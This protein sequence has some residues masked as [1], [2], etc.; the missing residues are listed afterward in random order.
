M[1]Y[2]FILVIN[3]LF[4]IFQAHGQLWKELPSSTI[5]EADQYTTIPDKYVIFQLDNDAIKSLLWSCPHEDGRNGSKVQ[6]IAF[7]LANG[8]LDDFKVWEYSMMEEKLAEKYPDIKTFHGQSVSN[9]Y[10]KIRIDYT[11]RGLRA[12]ISEQYQ[13]TYIEHLNRTD[14]SL[15]MVF[16]RRDFPRKNKWTCE[17]D[18]HLHGSHSHKENNDRNL[19]AGDCQFR[20]YRLAQATTGEYSNYHGAFNQGQSSLVM[21]AVTTTINRVNEVYEQD[22]TVRLILISNTD[23]LFF[24]DPATDPYTNNNGS[25]MLGQNITTCDARIGNAN[26]DIGHV[27][28]TGG[29]GV[30]Y[31]NA[32][33]NNSLKAGG[34]TGQNQPEGDPFDIDYVAHELGHQF[35]AN[36]TQNN[37]CNRNNATAM[38]PGSAS[39]IMGYA[40]ICSPNVQSNSDA[41]FHAISIQEMSNRITSTNCHTSISFPNNPP[42]LAPVQNYSIPIS[43]PFILTASATDPDNDPLT[44]CWEQ[45]DNQAAQMPP[46]SSNTSGPMFR[47]V[48]PVSSAS[49]YFPPLSNVLNNTTNT[50]Q[51]LPSVGRD[52]NFRVTV[53]DIPNINGNAGCTTERNL[54][55]TT[56]V[57]AGPFVVTSQNSPTTWFE[58]ENVDI[59]WN[60]ANTDQSPI[61]CT[62]VEILLSYDGG[63]N[64]TS[65]LAA[66]APNNGLATVTVPVGTTSQG[67]IIIRAVG[68]VF[69]DVNNANITIEPGG[70]TFLM[71]VSPSLVNECNTSP[72]VVQVNTTSLQGFNGNV[73]LFATNLPPNAIA[74]FNPPLI[75][76]GQSSTL[77]ISNLNGNTGTFLITIR[78]ISGTIIRQQGV[79]INLFSP[80]Q[81]V[82]LSSPANNATNIPLRATLSWQT[83]DSPEYEYQISKNQSFTK[84]IYSGTTAELNFTTPDFLIGD[85]VYYW[86]VKT[87]NPCGAENWSQTRQFTT[88]K[89][90]L[91]FANDLPIVISGS[92][93]PT[94]NSYFT[95]SDRGTMTDV[96]VI[97]L[98]GRHTWI[99]D[100]DFTLYRPGNNTGRVIWNRPCGSEDDFNI[101]FD[102][103]A[104]AGGWPCPPTDGRT[105]RPSNTLAWFNN[106]QLNGQWRLRVR[107]FVNQDGGFLDSW[108][109]KI[110]ANNYCRINV[111]H[112]YKDG[113]GSLPAA[114]ACAQSGD[115]ITLTNSIHN[116]TIC[117]EE[118]SILINKNLTIR[119][120]QGSVVAVRSDSQNPAFRI[121]PGF[122]VTLEGFE[123]I[124]S[125]SNEASLVNEGN[126]IMR[127]MKIGIKPGN[128][129]AITVRNDGGTITV[130]G[131]TVLV[132]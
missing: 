127:D 13:K 132:E 71:S 14:K 101:N 48:I 95:T 23:T 33:C 120:A 65:V 18:E 106:N 10:R 91:N 81:V 117:L 24:Y 123:I 98:Q 86:R 78:A 118:V 27:Y 122:N 51:V 85:A 42:S 15:R 32:V 105:Y 22:I 47:S 115:I 5:A 55:V 112:I 64:F 116:D 69:Y 20:T 80:D 67:R 125:D 29:G 49:R 57:S 36:H 111:D 60:V 1:H 53:R 44:Y 102:D 30:A 2:K 114:V 88:Q 124:G 34:V 113:I 40:G 103:A 75:Q 63:N 37:N 56:V 93:T 50:W 96:D 73:Q 17:F 107:D 38:E 6:I 84:I 16:H 82:Q 9:P 87:V 21:S 79:T 77:T 97:Q 94:I 129:S 83:L 41:Y 110:C 100:L 68:N 108:G 8:E 59:T 104:P 35:G 31:L 28:S 43:T 109:L 58:G 74:S 72:V 90:G 52:M 39:T 128:A 7:P 119:A 19:R 62:N 3:L 54:T 25:Q 4:V 126:L 66:N 76:A 12:V 121:L 89:C 46:Q 92:G 99:N 61:N 11:E 70:E 131:N 130:Q 45:M 26:Y